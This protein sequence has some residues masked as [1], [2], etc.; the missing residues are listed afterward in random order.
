MITQ[1]LTDEQREIIG[2]VEKLFRLAGGTT[3]EAEAASAASKAQ[4]L[5]TAYNLTAASLGAG[6]SD[7]R[8]AEELLRGGFYAYERELWRHVAELNFCLY[9]TQQ[10][11]RPRSESELRHAKVLAMADPWRRRN[12]RVTQHRLV[13]RAVC[14]AAATATAT[15]VLQSA[16]R[17]VREYVARDLPPSRDGE[18]V[19]LAQAL[20]SRRAVSF[21]EGVVSSVSEKL[22]R[23][24]RAAVAAEEAAQEEARRAAD[25]AAA[26]GAST[27]AALTISSLRQSEMDA[28]VDY[29][30]GAGWSAEQRR[31]RAERARLAR[32]AD[33]AAA[34]WALANPEEAA[35]Q[36]AERKK[37]ARRRGSGRGGSRWRG[38]RAEREPD[39]GAWSAGREAGVSVGVDPQAG[40]AGRGRG[41]SETRRLG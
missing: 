29:L 11:W 17:L 16:E 18:V 27:S 30:N 39:W 8:R 37:E 12:V 41:V 40:R 33:E 28:N 4:E 3:S 20:R 9:W 34:A 24:R 13:G 10:T 15:Y 25:A 1:S 21:R 22:I 2:K 19:G 14:V 38:G 23:Q 5:L 31:L 32:E 7:G 6:E 36:E 26:A 35:R